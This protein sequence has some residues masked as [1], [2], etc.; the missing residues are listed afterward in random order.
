MGFAWNGENGAYNGGSEREDKAYMVRPKRAEKQA[1]AT[2]ERGTRNHIDKIRLDEE[3]EGKMVNKTSK[4][5]KGEREK[6]G[7]RRL[8]IQWL[9]GLNRGKQ[10]KSRRPR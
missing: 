4:R 5:R 10:A 3:K 6:E 2:G 1:K 9:S 7:G 8:G